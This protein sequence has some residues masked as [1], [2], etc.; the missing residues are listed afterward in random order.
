MHHYDLTT[1]ERRETELPP[2]GSFIVGTSPLAD[3]KVDVPGEALRLQYD[4]VLKLLEPRR[5][6]LLRSAPARVS[7]PA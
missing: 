2:N 7:Q 4:G 5:V 6:V 3:F 1:L